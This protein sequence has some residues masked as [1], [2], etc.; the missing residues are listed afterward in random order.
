[1]ALK[2]LV[3]RCGS[4]GLLAIASVALGQENIAT[5]APAPTAEG[6]SGSSVHLEEALE[7]V[8]VTGTRIVRDG[9]AAPTPV[10]VATIDELKQETP[11]NIADALNKLPQFAGSTTLNST[12]NNSTNTAGN[13]LNLRS[14][15]PVRTL[16]LLNGQRVPATNF[17]GQVDVNTLPQALVR[18]VDVVTGGASAVY[19]SDA[20]TGVVNFV[21]DTRFTGLKVEAAGGVS[22]QGDAPTAKFSLAGGG[23]VFER[24][25]FIFSL[26]HYNIGGL[27]QTDRAYSSQDQVYAGAGTAA[28]PYVL[29]SNVRLSNEAYGGLV[30]SGPFAGQQFVGGG[31]LAPFNKGTPTKTNNVSVGGDGAYYYGQPLSHALQTDQGFGRFQFEFT[32]AVTGYVQFSL[33]QAKTHFNAAVATDNGVAIYSGNAFLPAAAQA[34]LTARGTTSFAM[35]VLPQNLTLQSELYQTTSAL[36]ATA[37]LTGR[38]FDDRYTWDIYY[39]HGKGRT[40]SD[41][42]NNIN[43][44]KFY[45][46]LDAVRDPAGNA[47]CRVTLTNPAQFPGCVPLN[48]FGASNESQAALNY[49]YGDSI[50]E[51]V[52]K[53]DDVATSIA[54]TAFNDWAGPVSVASNFEYRSQSLDMTS[55]SSPLS[56]PNYTGIRVGPAVPTLPWQYTTMSPQRGANSVWEVS[57]ETVVPLLTDKPLMRNLEVSGAARYTDYSSSGAVTTWKAGLNY[58]PFDDLRFRGTESRDI[59]APTLYDL[60]AGPTYSVFGFTDPHTGVTGSMPV[61]SLGNTNLVPEVARTWTA[62]FVYTPSWLPRFNLAVDY[63]NIAIDNAIGTVAGSSGNAVAAIQQCESSGGSS[64][65]CALFVRPLAFSNTSAANFPVLAINQTV[66]IAQQFTHGVDVEA[67]Y[68]LHLAQLAARLRGQL[69]FRLLYTYQPVMTSRAFAGAQLVNSAGTQGFAAERATARLAYTVGSFA[70][71][72]QT[73]YSGRENRGTGNPSQSFAGGPLPAIYYHDLSLSYHFGPGGHDLQ[74]FFTVNNLF[75]QQPRI[76][77]STTFTGIPGFGSPAVAG[78]DV[79]GR[80]FTAGIRWSY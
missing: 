21:L 33:A 78:D 11:S 4:A 20:V 40:R 62:G 44:Q 41:T 38:I 25:H 46:A 31:V 47:V 26:E 30:T 72:W 18:R 80:Y 7:N 28:N 16:I 56:T 32:D 51:A 79:L 8:T 57:A 15:G 68:S 35:N 42:T 63:F 49:I 60:Y 55:N 65:L 9:Y 29:T 64:P 50:W 70:G 34:L 58:Q 67:G 17:N 23:S 24:G 39:I 12:S 69:D 77:P 71:G 74:T 75:N 66:N 6:A 53:T 14:F 43:N 13:F 19:G 22:G 10:T 48:L 59:R 61:K 1:M 52:T 45:A 73:R 76:S 27:D 37:G 3:A 5:P 54:G 2:V 36:S